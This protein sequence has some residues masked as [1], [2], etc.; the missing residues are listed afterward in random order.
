MKD[1]MDI[2]IVEYEKKI[3]VAVD[4]GPFYILEKTSPVIWLLD[5][6][7]TPD[8]YNVRIRELP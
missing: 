2:L 8:N 3:E 5:T 7:K 4:H 1:K 6:L